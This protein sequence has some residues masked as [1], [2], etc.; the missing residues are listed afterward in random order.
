MISPGFWIPFTTA[1]AFF[2][3][4]YLLARRLSRRPL[5]GVDAYCA[6]VDE[7]LRAGR[8]GG[9]GSLEWP[10]EDER[11]IDFPRRL[12]VVRGGLDAAGA[13]ADAVWPEP[14]VDAGGMLDGDGL[15]GRAA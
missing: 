13:G 11:V 15:G 1:L 10:A 9:V 2:G 4:V 6:R 12:R 7:E 5:T 3:G 8:P 14:L